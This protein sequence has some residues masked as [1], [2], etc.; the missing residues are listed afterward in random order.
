MLFNFQTFDHF[1]I[2]YCIYIL[3]YI[4]V[5]SDITPMLYGVNSG[6]LT[7]NVYTVTFMHESNLPASHDKPNQQG[8]CDT[9]GHQTDNM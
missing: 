2:F 9:P 7:S 4:N 8:L 3:Y 6:I 5:P 1:I